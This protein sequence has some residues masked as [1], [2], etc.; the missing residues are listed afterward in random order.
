MPKATETLTISCPLVND[1]GIHIRT[2]AILTEICEC[3][4]AD[5]IIKSP[6]GES[7]GRDMMR[8]LMLEASRGTTLTI[9]ATGE[10]AQQALDELAAVIASGFKN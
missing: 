7:E 3:F 4:N 10:Q 8:L 2:A 9:Q 5:I 1:H 6:K